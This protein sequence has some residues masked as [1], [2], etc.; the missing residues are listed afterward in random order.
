MINVECYYCGVMDHV[1]ARC[2]HTK[3]DLKKL[4]EMN[5]HDDNSQ[6]NVVRIMEDE[7]VFLAKINEVATSK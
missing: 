1:Q 7:D 5:K 6:T 2:A 3:E 4:R